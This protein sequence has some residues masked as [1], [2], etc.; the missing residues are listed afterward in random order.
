MVRPSAAKALGQEVDPD[1]RPGEQVVVAEVRRFLAAQRPAEVT[2]AVPALRRRAAE[3]V[4]AEL[5]RLDAR[6]PGVTGEVLAELS[7]TVQRVVD[8]LLHTP[9]VR[10]K[11]L[12]GGP[13]GTSYAEALRELFALDPHAVAP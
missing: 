7:R 2:P 12:A 6:L 3:V 11:Q 5:L 13:T 10:I 4:D 9:T 8:K 1:R